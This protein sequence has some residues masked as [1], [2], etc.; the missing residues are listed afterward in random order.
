M[1]ENAKMGETSTKKKT[2]DRLSAQAKVYKIL[3]D[4]ELKPDRQEIS[5]EK[6]QQ[7][8]QDSASTVTQDNSNG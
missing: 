4:Q 3:L 5:C 2:A 1:R 6:S 7:K 8:S